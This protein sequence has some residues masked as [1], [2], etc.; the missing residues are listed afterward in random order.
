MIIDTDISA[1]VCL[2]NLYRDVG[3]V[4]VLLLICSGVYIEGK[5]GIEQLPPSMC[6]TTVLN[7]LFARSEFYWVSCGL[8]P[9]QEGPHHTKIEDIPTVKLWQTKTGQNDTFNLP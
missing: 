9:L 4:W 6:A 5:G 3:A 7:K 2:R 1:G 8:F